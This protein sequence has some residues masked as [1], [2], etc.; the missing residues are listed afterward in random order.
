ME[1]VRDQGLGVRGRQVVRDQESGIRKKIKSF[2]ELTV[3]QKSH[4]L[5]L[6]IY[7]ITKNYPKDERFALVSQMRRS[8]ISVPANIAEGF[9][10]RG[11]NNKINF[12]NIAQGSLDEIRYYVILS[13]DLG[14][15][16]NHSYLIKDIDEIGKMLN[17]MISSIRRRQ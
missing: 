8:S 15:I 3:W 17:G 7:K 1:V 12:Y 13:K 5:V 9:G 11:K 2:E 4:H 6:E 16:N 14:Y 10:K